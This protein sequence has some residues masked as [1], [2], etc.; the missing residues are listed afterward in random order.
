MKP[1]EVAYAASFFI[2]NFMGGW[3]TNGITYKG[4]NI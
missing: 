4:V 1:Q 2:H 3:H